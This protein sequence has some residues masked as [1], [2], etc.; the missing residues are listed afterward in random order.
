MVL[1]SLTVKSLRHTP[2]W[3]TVGPAKDKHQALT[4]RWKWYAMV[5]MESE[6][7]PH[8]ELHVFFIPYDVY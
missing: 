2:S 5:I 4:H 7:C 3:A 1:N 8:R 6:V